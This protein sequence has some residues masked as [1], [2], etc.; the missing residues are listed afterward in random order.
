MEATYTLPYGIEIYVNDGAGVVRTSELM[1][2]LGDQS[3]VNA[4][5]SYLLALACA[6]VDL[7]QPAFA[8]SLKDTVEAFGNNAC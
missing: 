1:K 2:E 8:G 5:E 7:S 4:L 6:G 3:F